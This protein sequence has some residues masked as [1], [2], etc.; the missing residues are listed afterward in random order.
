MSM[1]RVDYLT[2]DPA[3]DYYKAIRAAKTKDELTEAIKIYVSVAPDAYDSALFLTDEGFKVFKTKLKYAG[4][5]MPEKWTIEFFD[6]Y[7]DIVMPA[8]MLAA[9]LMANQLHVPW[10]TAFI[11]LEEMQSK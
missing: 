7:G 2:D 9:S 3:K 6:R 11:R 5:K 10:G 1:F 8:K 4:R